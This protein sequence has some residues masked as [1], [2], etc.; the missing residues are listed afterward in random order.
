MNAGF[1]PDKAMEAARAEL[2]RAQLVMETRPVEALGHL[3]E[4]RR[5]DPGS[6]D[7]AV[8]LARV[9]VRL[10]R[11]SDA[12]DSLQ[13]VLA[14]EETCGEA[15]ALSA[16][17]QLRMGRLEQADEGSR[18]ALALDAGN[19]TAREVLADSL[20]A[21]ARWH[22][23]ADEIG[24]LIGEGVRLPDSAKA[25]LNL[26]LAQCLLRAG[27]HPQS[28]EI[29]HQML[30]AGYRGEQV[31]AVHRES[32]ALNKAEIRAAFGKPGVLQRVLLW[33]A[34]KH[35]LSAVSWGRRR[36]QAVPGS[37]IPQRGDGAPA[38]PA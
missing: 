27:A 19:R 20:R 10:A 28:W 37:P 25:R 15:L 4:G 9:E 11:Y 8:N 18:A 26:K 12:L 7:I 17:C 22:E 36:G 29:T 21:R 1:S 33:L 30:K 38:G 16:L 23:A 13:R 32:E 5:L 24:V 6:M 31:K 3:A 14:L 2:Q 35:I 34:D